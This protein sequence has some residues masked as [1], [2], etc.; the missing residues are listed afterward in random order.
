MHLAASMPRPQD[1]K[2]APLA[3]FVNNDIALIWTLCWWLVAYSP[4][5]YVERACSQWYVLVSHTPEVPW[6]AG[7][8]AGL[9][10]SFA[11]DRACGWRSAHAV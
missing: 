10:Q 8:L 1:P 4:G 5:G 6:P 9:F 11:C 7:R 3:F 2:R